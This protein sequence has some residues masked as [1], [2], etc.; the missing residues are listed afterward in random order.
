ME[1]ELLLP[2]LVSEKHP[3]KVAVPWE[4]PT[5]LNFTNSYLF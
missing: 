5:K 4:S 1:Y 3:T 2:H